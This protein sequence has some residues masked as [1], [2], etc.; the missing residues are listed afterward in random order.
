MANE[1]NGWIR[2]DELTP[3][4]K[5]DLILLICMDSKYP[6]PWLGNILDYFGKSGSLNAYCGKVTHWQPVPKN[7]I[8]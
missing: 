2:C 8:K 4:V 7:P 3:E 6:E 1:N 5:D